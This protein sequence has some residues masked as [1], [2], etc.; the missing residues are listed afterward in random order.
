MT[1]CGQVDPDLVW[2]SGVDVYF[3]EGL[4][5]SRI[6]V[7]DVAFRVGWFAGGRGCVEV[8]DFRVRDRADGCV[9]C[10]LV[11]HCCTLDEGAV[12]FSDL[13]VVKIPEEGLFGD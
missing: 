6:A 10:E 2:A 9:H 4:I 5:L 3:D 12:D 7:E 8:S 13:V 1:G 11:G